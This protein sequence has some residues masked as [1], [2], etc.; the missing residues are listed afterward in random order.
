MSAVLDMEEIYTEEMTSE[1]FLKAY[2][3]ER[4]DIR[5]AMVKPGKFDDD[6]F[7]SIIVERKT[8]VY[9]H[10]SERLRKPVR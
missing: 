5:T 3:T 7:G 9:I 10:R 2:E 4:D 8:P 6:N 1:E